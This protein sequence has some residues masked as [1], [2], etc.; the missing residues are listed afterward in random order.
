MRKV[1]CAIVPTLTLVFGLPQVSPGVAPQKPPAPKKPVVLFFDDF[2]GPTLNRSKWNVLVTGAGWETVNNE[3]Q[4]YVDSKE[5]ISFVSGATAEGATHGALVIRPHFRKAFTTPGGQKYDFISGRLDTR[6][7]LEF[8]HGTASARIKMS[9]GSGLWP[10]FW[11]LGPGS[12]PDTGEIDILENVG[13]ADWVSSALHGPG[14]SGGNALGKRYTLPKDKD[15]TAWHI[16]SVDWTPQSIVFK[17]DGKA[18]HKVTRPMVEKHGRWVYDTPEFV[19]LNFAL[20]GGYPQSVNQVTSPYPGLPEST[21]QLV[22]QKKARMLVD[23][24]R[25]TRVGNRQ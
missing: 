18:F 2:S 15:I 24:V 1:L 16:Y 5:T 10:A 4:A 7:K 20:G 19:V 25:V 11:L 13:M 23:W 3:Q 21:V 14:Y 8:T 17:V 9:A 22:K 12:W 6:R